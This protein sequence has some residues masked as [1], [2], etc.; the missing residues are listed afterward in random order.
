[1]RTKKSR[2]KVFQMKSFVLGFF[3]W[4]YAVISVSVRKCKS[5]IT[6]KIIPYISSRI[7]EYDG[8]IW[9]GRI[10]M[11]WEQ[12]SIIQLIANWNPFEMWS[13]LMSFLFL[14]IWNVK[15]FN[16]KKKSIEIYKQCAIH[17]QSILISIHLFW[18]DFV[19]F[20]FFTVFSHNTF[21]MCYV[22]P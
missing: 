19:Y 8:N 22:F 20:G 4:K 16:L 2:R 6:P 11:S 15:R 7:P 12:N 5:I 3:L 21:V 18:A 14:S 9:F 17:L 10:K 1:M 13:Q